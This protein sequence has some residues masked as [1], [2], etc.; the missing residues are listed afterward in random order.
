MDTGQLAVLDRYLD[1]ELGWIRDSLRFSMDTIFEIKLF[2]D[3]KVLTK[4]MYIY[5]TVAFFLP[6]LQE[7][8]SNSVQMFN[9]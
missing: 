2:H 1:T 9:V 8:F 4:C 7:K 3:L 5:D 6:I